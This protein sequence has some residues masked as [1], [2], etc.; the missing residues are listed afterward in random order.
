DPRDRAPGVPLR[1]PAAAVAVHLRRVPGGPR[2]PLRR[3]DGPGVLG[4]APGGG[5]GQEARPARTT[6]PRG[7]RRP[8]L[9]HEDHPRRPADPGRPGRRQHAGAHRRLRQFPA[10]PP[11]QSGRPVVRRGPRIDQRHVPR[12]AARAGSAPGRSRPADPH[13]ADC[14]GAAYV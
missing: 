2:R 10:R 5:A 1:I 9:R 11:H 12:P 8:A 13:R 14:P 3:P 6:H 4:A 7:D